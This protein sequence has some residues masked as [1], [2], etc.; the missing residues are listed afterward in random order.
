MKPLKHVLRTNMHHLKI[1]CLGNDKEAMREL[2]GIIAYDKIE[3]HKSNSQDR[4]NDK[5]QDSI[6]TNLRNSL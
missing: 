4:T 3:K 6:H 1:F 5:V 2:F